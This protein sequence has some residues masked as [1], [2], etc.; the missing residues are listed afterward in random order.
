MSIILKT[1]LV[2]E[3]CVIAD[4][5]ISPTGCVVKKRERSTGIIP[6]PVSVAQERSRTNGRI[7]IR[8]ISKECT[9]AKA[10]IEVRNGIA[11]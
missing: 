10:R 2:M 4:R 7:V 6:I 11:S 9:S 8:C 1:G 3:Q 5:V